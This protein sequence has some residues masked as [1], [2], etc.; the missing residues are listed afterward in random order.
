MDEKQKCTIHDFALTAEPLKG[1]EPLPEDYLL[2][3][4]PCGICG[5]GILQHEWPFKEEK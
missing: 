1:D 4:E 5:K 3:G 2:T